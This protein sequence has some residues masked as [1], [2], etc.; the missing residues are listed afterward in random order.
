MDAFREEL[1]LRL[2]RE[3]ATSH[4]TL[5]AAAL[6]ADMGVPLQLALATLAS[7]DPM[8]RFAHQCKARCVFCLAR[9]VH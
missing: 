6:L 9:A 2:A 7:R 1:M 3:L 5:F 8:D 4:G